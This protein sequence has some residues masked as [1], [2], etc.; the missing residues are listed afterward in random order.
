VKRRLLIV[1]G[2]L[3]GAWLVACLFLFM[4]PRTDELPARADAVVVLSGDRNVRLDPGVR[5]VEQG[6]APVLAISSTLHD[7]RWLKAR[8]LCRRGRV[9]AATV[10]CFEP[11]PFSTR[12]EA[13]AIGRLARE[14]GWHRIVIVTSTF[15]LTRARM[16]FHRCYR[17]RLWAVGTPAKWWRLPEEWAFETG[18]LAVQ[19]T[20]ERGC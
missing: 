8:K 9:A 10:V 18:K 17:G 3:A 2:A 6:L 7:P 11:V 1:V 13:R 15:H 12:G 5:L 19:L 20:F 16:V 4:W 14:H